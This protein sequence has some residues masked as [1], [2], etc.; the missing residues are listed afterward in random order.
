MWISRNK[1]VDVSM[2]EVKSPRYS[3]ST[4]SDLPAAAELDIGDRDLASCRV[5]ER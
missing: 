3:H 1:S 4:I 5:G 2:A